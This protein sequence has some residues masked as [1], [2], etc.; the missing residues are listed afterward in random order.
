MERLLKTLSFIF[1]F[2]CFSCSL[3]SIPAYADYA[4]KSARVRAL[5]ANC[6]VNLSLVTVEVGALVGNTGGSRTSSAD[7]AIGEASHSNT[8]NHFTGGG[9]IK[10]TFGSP[11][12][13]KP[14]ILGHVAG[15]ADSSNTLIQQDTDTVPNF[16]SR[17]LLENNWIVRVIAGLESKPF[18][19]N[20]TAG[21]GVGTA[22]IGQRLKGRVTLLSTSSASHTKTAFAPSILASLTWLACDVCVGGHGGSI[23]LQLAADQ[24]PGINLSG[25]TAS[26]SLFKFNVNQKWQYSE[27]LVFNMRI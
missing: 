6:F 7:T 22:L 8:N 5:P 1:L 2:I 26:G 10:V 9:Q 21:L 14:F 23:S 13:A 3:F 24:Y 4:K 18:F 12:S 19:N 27:M 15:I 20:M 11:A 16:S 17:L 25:Q